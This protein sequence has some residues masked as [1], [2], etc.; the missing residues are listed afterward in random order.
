VSPNNLGKQEK[1]LHDVLEIDW[2][3]TRGKLWIVQTCFI[4]RPNPRTRT[5]EF[6]DQF[7]RKRHRYLRPGESS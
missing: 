7:V 2:K 3:R 6:L 4:C 5:V 1:S